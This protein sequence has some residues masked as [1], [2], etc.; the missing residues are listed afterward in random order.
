MRAL[1]GPAML[2]VVV[3]GFGLY[4][5]LSS[6][7]GPPRDFLDRELA[8]PEDDDD[9]TG[10]CFSLSTVIIA[11]TMPGSAQISW[12]PEGDDAWILSLEDVV[13]DS[14]GPVNVFQRFTFRQ[15]DDLIHLEAV[16]ASHGRETDVTRN[17]DALLAEPN[18]RSTPVD[19]CL[20]SDAGGYHFRPRR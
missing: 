1:A 10:T 19:R 9:H 20:G 18:R 17:L 15:R 16:E 14:R 5:A 2:L 7:E 6:P 4:R 12:T 11:N 13:R 8:A 3:G